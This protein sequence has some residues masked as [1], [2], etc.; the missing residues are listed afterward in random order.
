MSKP[1]ADPNNDPILARRRELGRLAAAG[2]RIGY[3]LFGIAMVV[4]VIAF[5]T[6]FNG[7]VVPIVALALVIGSVVLA[8]S[9][10]MSY[11]VRAADREDRMRGA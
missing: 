8:P 9:M 6:S 11:G 7:A 10:V 5:F 1:G 2:K 3:S 4:F